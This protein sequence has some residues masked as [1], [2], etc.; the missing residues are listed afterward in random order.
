MRASH[1]QHKTD[2]KNKSAR[3][4]G[5]NPCSITR[6][7]LKGTDA[8]LTSFHFLH[9]GNFYVFSYEKGGK[10]NHTFIDT[11]DFRYRDQIVPILTDNG[12]DPANIER[13]IISHRHPDHSGLAEILARQSKAKI[14][15]HSNFRAFVE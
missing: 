14:L 6:E 9:D 4:S 5:G 7:R 1:R 12:I 11:G 13:I 2:K 3:R 8:D 10:R 15:V